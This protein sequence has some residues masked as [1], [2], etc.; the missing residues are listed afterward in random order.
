MNP[1]RPLLRAKY[2]I[3]QDHVRLS[4]ERPVRVEELAVRRPV[5]PHDHAYHEVCLV[6]AGTG[7]HRTRACEAPLRAGSLVVLPPGPAGVHAIERVDGLVVVNVYYLA[8]W[9]LTDLGLLW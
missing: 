7:L 4:A 3:S 6:L 9:L 2:R 1:T 5:A 8:E